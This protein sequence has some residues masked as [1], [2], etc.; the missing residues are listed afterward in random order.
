MGLHD[1]PPVRKARDDDVEEATDDEAKEEA[2]CLE[3][4]GRK[5]DPIVQERVRARRI[6]A[7]A[8]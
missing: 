4:Q 7:A 6:P 2:R 5:H 8:T 3:E 1:A